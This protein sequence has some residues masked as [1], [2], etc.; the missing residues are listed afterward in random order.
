MPGGRGQREKASSRSVARPAIPSLETF[1][2]FVVGIRAERLHFLPGLASVS[3]GS[4]LPLQGGVQ[5]QVL[6]SFPA[7]S[8]ADNPGCKGL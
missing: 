1:S 6:A 7:L 3:T 5:W 8:S 2:F 4:E